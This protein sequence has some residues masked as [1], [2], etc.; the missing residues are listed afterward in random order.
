MEGQSC[1]VGFCR[2]CVR[3]SVTVFFSSARPPIS[4]SSS[5][6]LIFK[7]AKGLRAQSGHSLHFMLSIRRPPFNLHS[8]CLGYYLRAC[9]LCLSLSLPLSPSLSASFPFSKLSCFLSCGSL[10]MRI[11]APLVSTPPP[12]WAQTRGLCSWPAFLLGKLCVKD[13]G[14]S[15]REDCPLLL[16]G[17]GLRGSSPLRVARAGQALVG[18]P[19][20]C[21]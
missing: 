4:V 13:E 15:P 17:L 12:G 20:Q 6:F 18:E 7:K 14:D 10:Q 8:S 9:S 19:L 3:R 5:F 11:H 16:G 21:G 2:I 1:R